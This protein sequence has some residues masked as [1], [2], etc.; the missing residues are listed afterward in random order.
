[1]QSVKRIGTGLCLSALMTAGGTFG[2]FADVEHGNIQVIQNDAGN[3]TTSVTVTKASGTANF[4]IRDG[5]NRGDYNVTF[6]TINDVT[7]GVLLTSVRQ[8]GRDNAAPPNSGGYNGLAGIVFM[9][10]QIERSADNLSYYIPIFHAPAGDETNVDVA[11]GHFKYEDGWI[12]GIALNLNPDGTY[13]NN[14]TLNT[15][16]GSPGITIGTELTDPADTTG[17]YTLNLGVLGSSQ[18]GILLVNGAKNEDN[19]ALSQANFDGT[20]TI[21]CH[22]NGANARSYEN[23]PVAFVYIPNTAVNLTA[24]R[25][26]GDGTLELVI[27]GGT[28]APTIVQ[29]TDGSGNLI[30]RYR[31][32]IAGQSPATG[33]LLISPEGNNNLNVDNIVTYEADGDGWIIESRDLPGA[34]P[35]LQFVDATEGCFSFA[36][37]PNS[38]GIAPRA[39]GNTVSGSVVLPTELQNCPLNRPLT[40]TFTPT[41][42]A[43]I[44]RTVT[45]DASGSF[46]SPAVPAGNYRL[47]ARTDYTLSDAEDVNLSTGNV[48]NIQINLRGGDASND[49]AVDITDL[50][51][52]IGAYNQAAPAVGY[53]EAADFNCDDVNDITDL[54]ILIGN[55]NQLGA[56]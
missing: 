3:T 36:F 20:F 44:V 48:T 26:L 56:Q 27:N 23:D 7:S 24:G 46:T 40:L 41:T 34:P 39:V 25:V 15:F 28:G 52:L 32:T 2:A 1:M 47:S 53:L 45:P 16:I 50:L 31:L 30:G 13:N 10:S 18:S 55:Y 49:N 42:G 37:L 29:Q 9:T 6:N 38:G 54:L 14:T 5:S 12:G 22:D 4:A 43:P 51:A 33:T 21:I 17:T 19:Y 35:G 8:N 11:V